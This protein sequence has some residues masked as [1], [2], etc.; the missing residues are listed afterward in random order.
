MGSIMYA[1]LAKD[2]HSFYPAT[3]HI[4]PVISLL[5]SDSVVSNEKSF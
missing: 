3:N 1:I 4:S 5:D 2:K